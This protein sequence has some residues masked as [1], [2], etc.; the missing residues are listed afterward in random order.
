MLE[1]DAGWGLLQGNLGNRNILSQARAW[2][3]LRV[4]PASKKWRHRD[5][6]FKSILSYIVNLW[7]AWDT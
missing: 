7:P 6:K 5:Q 3:H 2:G 4:I 1:A